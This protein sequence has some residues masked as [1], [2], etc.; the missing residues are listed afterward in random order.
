MLQLRAKCSWLARKGEGHT[1]GQFSV[2]ANKQREALLASA[3]MPLLFAARKINGD[4]YS[5]GAQDGWQKMQ[6]NT[7]VRPLIDVGCQ[8]VIVTHL[9]DGSLWSLHEFPEVTFME[10]R[11]QSA[12]TRDSLLK[13]L[14]GFDSQKIPF[15]IDQGYKDSMHCIGRIM[16][17]IKSVSQLRASV[18]SIAEPGRGEKLDIAV[19]KQ[20]RALKGG[21]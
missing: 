19:E 13:D 11:P 12:I 8:T 1:P 16:K 18:A 2:G 15:W 10:I 17:S 5:V 7:P 6:G 9:L 20:M 4:L 21:L 3:A 14:L